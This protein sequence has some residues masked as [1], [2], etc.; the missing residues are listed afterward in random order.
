M[1]ASNGIVLNIQEARIDASL[2]D[3]SKFNALIQVFH[4]NTEVS[5]KAVSCSDSC[6]RWNQTFYLEKQSESLEL[7]LVHKPLLLKEQVLATCFL[8]TNSQSGWTRL[9][10][11]RQ[12]IASL[13]LSI[14]TEASGSDPV[15][16]TD[17]FQRKVSEVQ[18]IKSKLDNYKVL[19]E[20]EKCEQK[21]IHP[22]LEEMMMT[23]KVEQEN[24]LK[25]FNEINENK[26]N[27][28]ELQALVLKE[29]GKVLKAKEEVEREEGEVKREQQD[30]QSDFEGLMIVK[31]KISLQERI[32]KGYHRNSKSESKPLARSPSNREVFSALLPSFNLSYNK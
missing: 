14:L 2:C 18:S 31:N 7:R 30:L 10:K 16:M 20:T 29:K 12:K 24:Y 3:F 21:T 26:K 13:K 11:S 17:L 28:E 19:Y 9:F 6:P 15:D 32:L 25:I 1:K 27:L 5:T 4:G 22:K 23:L 8:S